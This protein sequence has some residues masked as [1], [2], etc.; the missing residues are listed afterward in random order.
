VRH[1]RQQAQAA[2]GTPLAAHH[3]G[4]GPGFVDED[5]TGGIERR[6]TANEDPPLFRDFGAI[7]FGGVKALFLSVMFCAWRNR[8]KLARP[9]LTPQ[10]AKAPR[11]SGKVKSVQR[12]V[13]SPLFPSPRLFAKAFSFRINLFGNR[14][15]ELSEMTTGT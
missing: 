13:A 5:Q 14:S 6:V 1:R 3:I 4:G 8:H 9:T 11:I 12:R 2:G 10:P 15:S 7:L